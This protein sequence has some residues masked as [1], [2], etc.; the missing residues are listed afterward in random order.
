MFVN[1]VIRRGKIQISTQELS[2]PPK[3]PK[4]SLPKKETTKKRISSVLATYSLRI[5]NTEGIL[6]IY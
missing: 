1:I 3:G 6:K 5:G 4:N 2:S